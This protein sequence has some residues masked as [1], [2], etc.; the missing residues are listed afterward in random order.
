VAHCPPKL[1]DDVADV[2]G[3]VRAWAGIVERTAGV[4]YLHR[5]P[6]LH[7]HLMAGGGRRAD[8]K[9][10]AGWI[11]LDLPRRPITASRRG[12]LL[13]ELRTRY[14]ERLRSEG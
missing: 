8:V 1:L 2:L 7:F 3:K 5:R 12:T 10:R 4:L 6:F 14:R 13:R 9:G 11:S